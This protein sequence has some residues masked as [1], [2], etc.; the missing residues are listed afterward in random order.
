MKAA[1]YQQCIVGF[2]KEDPNAILGQLS[3][4][5]GFTLEPAQRDAWL[6]QI[7]ILKQALS[8][9]AKGHL[10]FEFAIP[11]MGK[12]ADVVIY[13]EGV[14][15]VV[16]FKVGASAFDRQAIE[17]VHD[18]ALD[19]K[20][21]HRGSHDLPIVPILVATAAPTWPPQGCSGISIKS[22]GPS[23]SVRTS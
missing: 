6:A 22:R 8:P 10:L 15:V 23:P 4:A 9:S 17:Q 3:R 11:R 18:Y 21:F 14:V 19:L 7:D 16:E 12:R 13:C 5:H 20:N 2:G 1:Y